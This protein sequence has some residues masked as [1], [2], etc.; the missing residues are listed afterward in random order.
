MTERREAG[1]LTLHG[2]WT[3]LAEGTLM[4]YNGPAG[5]WEQV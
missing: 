5:T 2:L 4:A 1:E 3:D